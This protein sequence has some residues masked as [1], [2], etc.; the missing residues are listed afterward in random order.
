[1]VPSDCPLVV[2]DIGADGFRVATLDQQDA[3]LGRFQLA[4]IFIRGYVAPWTR[5]RPRAQRDQ[6]L[7]PGA[8]RHPTGFGT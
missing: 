8:F 3:V 7:S 5:A 4:S 6:P 2:E 1:M